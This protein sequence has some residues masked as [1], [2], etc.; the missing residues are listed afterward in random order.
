MREMIQ[1]LLHYETSSRHAAFCVA[2]LSTKVQGR[3]VAV[4]APN[5]SGLVVASRRR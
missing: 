2:V 1:V 5:Y 4:T 3:I